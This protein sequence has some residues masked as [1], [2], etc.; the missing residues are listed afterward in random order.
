MFR[1]ALR[2]SLAVLLG[3]LA[4]AT[5]AHLTA[6]SPRCMIFFATVTSSTAP[7]ILGFAGD[8]AIANGR[9]AAIGRLTNASAARVVDATGLIVAPGIHRPPHAFRAPVTAGRHGAEQGAARR[10]ARYHG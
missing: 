5:A 4:V 6:Q 7:A 2:T 8:V 3:G 9:V 1:F 10:D